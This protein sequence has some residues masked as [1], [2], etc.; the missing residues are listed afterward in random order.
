MSG[1][2][3]FLLN[4]EQMHDSSYY[5]KL[6]SLY[7]ERAKA[8][9][10]QRLAKGGSLEY[11]EAWHMAMRHPLVWEKDLKEWIESWSSEG[12]LEIGGLFQRQKPQRKKG[13]TLTWRR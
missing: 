2:Q 1:G 8:D 6:R 3:T 4:A 11:D 5:D 7:L 9:I 10:K 12:L 13:I